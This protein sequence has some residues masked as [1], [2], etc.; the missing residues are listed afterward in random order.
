MNNTGSINSSK[1]YTSRKSIVNKKT[2]TI[3]QFRPMILSRHPSHNC[4]RANTKNIVPLPYRAVVRFG[5]T[6][7]VD[8]TITNGGNR[9]EINTVESIKNSANKLLMKQKFQQVAV[10]TAEWIKFTNLETLRGWSSEKFP[11]VAKAHFGSKGKGNSLIKTAEELESW[12]KT[13]SPS[14]YIF[15]K[16][17]NYGHEFR[18]HVTE[19][20]CF[21]ACRKALKQGVAEEDKWRRHD[22]ICVWFLE[23]NES[24]FKPNSWNDIIDDCV[25]AL[26]AIGADI[27]SFDVRVQ[28]PTDSKGN[29]RDYQDYILLECNSASSMDNGSGELSVCAKKYIEEVRKTIIYKVNKITR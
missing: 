20:G 29:L 8:D 15:E 4:L 22:D 12:I 7:E 28:S 17:M 13:H 11:I 18:L 16:F 9:I 21:Y 5:S 24:F 6:T 23:E 19:Q 1:L 27:L 14:S 10:K 26:K 3:T 2:K 25:S